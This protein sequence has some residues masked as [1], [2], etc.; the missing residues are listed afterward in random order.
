MTINELNELT[1]T[2]LIAIDD[3][4]IMLGRWEHRETKNTKNADKAVNALN[5]IAV[6]YS[7]VPPNGDAATIA[8]G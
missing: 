4:L 7:L 8:N 5:R 3:A 6:R 1:R 2:D